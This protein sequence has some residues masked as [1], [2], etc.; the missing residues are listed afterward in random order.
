MNKVLI[1]D[2]D[3]MI[4]LA[5][6]RGL[7]SEGF[8]VVEAANASEGLAAVDAHRPDVALVDVF[9]PEMNGLEL[10]RKIRALDRK[11]PMIFVTSDTSSETTIEAM[12]LGR[13][14]TWPS[15]SISSSFEILLLAPQSLVA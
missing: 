3:R 6:K 13:S 12:R 15:L 11:L 5:V 2:D 7:E 8:E 9:M 1:I 10:F 4:R 14:I